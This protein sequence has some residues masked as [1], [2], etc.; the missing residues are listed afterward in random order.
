MEM[1]F[2]FIL[3]SILYTIAIFIDGIKG[4]TRFKCHELG[5]RHVWVVKGFDENTYLVC[6]KC[7]TLPSG[8]TEER[9]GGRDDY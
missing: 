9:D 5:V 1:V 2:I 7:H 6:E 3:F 4:N 8:E